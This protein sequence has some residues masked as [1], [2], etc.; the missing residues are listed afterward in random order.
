MALSWE[1]LRATLSIAAASKPQLLEGQEGQNEC[2]HQEWSHVHELQIVL[3]GVSSML[4]TSLQLCSTLTL[5]P[6]TFVWC[7]SWPM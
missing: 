7:S 6:I 2:K 1:T 4:G 5:R 3:D